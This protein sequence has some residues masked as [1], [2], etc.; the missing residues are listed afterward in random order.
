MSGSE[1]LFTKVGM[2]HMHDALAN[3]CHQSVPDESLKEVFGLMPEKIK[4]DA[5]AWGLSDTVVREAMAEWA[6][7]NG[8]AIAKCVQ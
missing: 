6:R 5:L 2:A 8:E 7:A 3:G 1:R 4:E